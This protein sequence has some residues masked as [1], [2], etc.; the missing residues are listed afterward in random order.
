MILLALQAWNRA[1]FVRFLSQ[2]GPTAAARLDAMLA[3]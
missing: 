2:Q 1:D 3:S